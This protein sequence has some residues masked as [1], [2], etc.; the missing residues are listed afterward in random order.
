MPQITGD[1]CDDIIRY[2]QV[3]GFKDR[4]I[5]ILVDDVVALLNNNNYTIPSIKVGKPLLGTAGNTQ[6]Y[7]TLKTDK[8]KRLRHADTIAQRLGF[9]GIKE[10]D[11]Y[12]RHIQVK[13][14]AT[15]G[16]QKTA[17]VNA[18][19]DTLPCRNLNPTFYDH[20]GMMARNILAIAGTGTVD[21]SWDA[22]ASKV[23][24]GINYG[25]EFTVSLGASYVVGDQGVHASLTQ[26]VTPSSPPA[27]KVVT[28]TVTATKVVTPEDEEDTEETT[29]EP[30]VVVEEEDT[31]LKGFDKS[32]TKKVCDSF[33]TAQINTG[34]LALSIWEERAKTTGGFY[35]YPLD[36]QPIFIKLTPSADDNK[37]QVHK[38]IVVEDPSGDDW[39]GD[40]ANQAEGAEPAFHTPPGYLIIQQ[41]QKI[42][43]ITDTYLQNCE[44]GVVLT[45]GVVSDFKL[46]WEAPAGGAPQLALLEC[47]NKSGEVIFKISNGQIAELRAED[48]TISSNLGDLI[49][50][51]HNQKISNTLQIGV[52]VPTDQ[53][54]AQM[55]VGTQ[56]GGEVWI[57]YAFANLR[58]ADA[59]HL[60]FYST[61]VS[62]VA[63]ID[64]YVDEITDVDKTTQL[65]PGQLLARVAGKVEETLDIDK[66]YI[67]VLVTFDGVTAETTDLFSGRNANESQ[68]T[69]SEVFIF[70]GDE[71][72]LNPLVGGK[73]IF[74]E[75]GV[76]LDDTAER[77]ISLDSV[78][79][80]SP[81]EHKDEEGNVLQYS[82]VDDA[83]LIFEKD[84]NK[85]ILPIPDTN[86]EFSATD[87]NGHMVRGRVLEIQLWVGN[88]AAAY[89]TQR[90]ERRQARMGYD[91]NLR[92]PSATDQNATAAMAFRIGRKYYVVGRRNGKPVLVEVNLSYGAE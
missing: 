76:S 83:N 68:T 43:F 65:L 22:A 40:E 88:P 78:A 69:L 73:G 8:I 64:V 38:N 49:T 13:G 21:P 71:V 77:L 37:L 89:E 15:V 57:Q 70:P 1:Q 39:F 92:N 17:K 7:A 74:G 44:S 72:D 62:T 55:D 16:T 45:K 32:I 11:D 3:E 41:G 34:N 66:K 84:G 50:G 87:A 20:N 25:T 4:S 9:T 36:T 5:V 33:G 24:S 48:V 54:S 42:K 46:Q 6:R 53:T 56:D 82:L 51:I 79:T 52:G 58:G 12:T 19:G 47:M 67:K 85:I 90:S 86:Q 60:F 18:A 23:A 10:M 35:P 28:P 30:E 75:L 91:Y 61:E 63:T 59:G 2:L 26:P 81:Q 27:P 29:E 14:K 31:L 80:S